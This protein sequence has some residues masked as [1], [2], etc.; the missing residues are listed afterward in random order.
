L[1]GRWEAQRVAHRSTEGSL[2]LSVEEDGVDDRGPLVEG[3]VV[4]GQA[5]PFHLIIAD[6]EREQGDGDVEALRPGAGEGEVRG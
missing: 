1:R 2:Q 5:E 4:H 6:Q 3:I